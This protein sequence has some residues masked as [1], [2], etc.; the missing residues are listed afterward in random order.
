MR[1]SKGHGRRSSDAIEGAPRAA[2]CGDT[3]DGWR[4]VLALIVVGGGLGAWLWNG[5]QIDRRFGDNVGA[6]VR[7]L[8]EAKTQA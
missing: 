1:W 4:D 5:A 7:A 8:R 6:I 3:S 2:R